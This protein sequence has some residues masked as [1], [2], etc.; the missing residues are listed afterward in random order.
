MD[1][2]VFDWQGNQ[3]DLAYLQGKYG[4]FIIKPAADSDGTVYK[5]STLRE[6][7]DTAATLVVRVVNSDGAALDGV[8]MAWYWPDAPEDPDAGPLGSS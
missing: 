1:I 7:V 5:I 3:R 8:Q 4:Q 6:K 2:K